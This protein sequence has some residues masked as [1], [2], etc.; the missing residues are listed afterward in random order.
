MPATGPM[1]LPISLCRDIIET[2]AR[3]NRWPSGWVYDGKKNIYSPVDHFGRQRTTFEVNLGSEMRPRIFEVGIQY[4]AT[5]NMLNLHRYLERG[6]IPVP[7][8][9]IQS[10]EVTWYPLDAKLYCICRSA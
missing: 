3:Q 6:D 10:I 8:E 2:C 9:A 5:I 1:L 7:R 4:A